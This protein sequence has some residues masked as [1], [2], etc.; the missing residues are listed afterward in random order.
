[1]Q[2]AQTKGKIWRNYIASIKNIHD[3]FYISIFPC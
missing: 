2:T 1:V 3:I